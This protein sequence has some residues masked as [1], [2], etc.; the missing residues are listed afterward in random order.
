[1]SKL[2]LTGL[3]FLAVL[4]AGFFMVLKPHSSSAAFLANRIIDDPIFDNVGA[5][6]A[7]DINTFLNSLPNSCISPNSGFEARI[8][9]GYSPS[10]GFT[11]G[12]FVSAG[13]VIAQA[14]QA[15]GLNAQ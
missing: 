8:P 14:S 1:M 13:Q 12:D 9:T 10:T 3:L 2:K 11:F 7:G 15:Y 5:I 4:L 6:G